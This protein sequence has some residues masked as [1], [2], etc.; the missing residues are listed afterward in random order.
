MGIAGPVFINVFFIEL[1]IKTAM[2]MWTEVQKFLF[3]FPPSQGGMTAVLIGVMGVLALAA[4][5]DAR[6]GRVPG[7]LLA[8]CAVA[9]LV[10]SILI[11]GRYAAGQRLLVALCTMAFLWV[12]HE[13]YFRILGR[14]PFG[15]GDVKWSG[16][17]AFGFGLK[18]LGFAWFVAAWLGLLWMGARWLLG[19][20]WP[21][22]RG[23]G[24]IHFAPFLFL[25]L[26]F[27]LF[28]GV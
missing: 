3:S 9:A 20:V 25:A 16:L 7:A 14:D 6:T 18:A 21:R 19:F 5:Q 26:G 11:E 22:L 4:V 10:F 15:L 28:I 17:A 8:F 13:A 1:E 27:V 12:A 23:K 24:Y 2:N